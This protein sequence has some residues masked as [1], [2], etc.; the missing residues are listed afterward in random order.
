[1]NISE[2]E[3]LKNEDSPPKLYVATNSALR[4]IFISLCVN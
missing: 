3:S 2:V 1:M 4:N